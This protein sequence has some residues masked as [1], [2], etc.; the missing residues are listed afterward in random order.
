MRE[1]IKKSFKEIYDV[2]CER[3]YSHDFTIETIQL[4]MD[5][6]NE[7][8][9]KNNAE[10]VEKFR[11]QPPSNAPDF[12]DD[13]PFSFERIM[14]IFLRL[15]DSVRLITPASIQ[16]IFEVNSE[17]AWKDY[18]VRYRRYIY[19]TREN[20][21]D[22]E[23]LNYLAAVLYYDEKDFDMALKCIN[24][25]ISENSGSALYAH[26]KGLIL[27]HTGEFDSA[28]TYLYQALF[29]MELL[30]DQPPRLSGRP[31]IYPNY[32]IEYHTSADIIRMELN[33]IEQLELSFK[34]EVLALL[35]N[36]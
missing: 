26:L 15:D 24:Q 20:Y 33:K 25:A 18:Q 14:T 4:V 36:E 17:L 32:P 27:F 19:E 11:M 2:F 35:E 28:R 16:R 5:I 7:V 21:P 10:Y 30:Q 22:D 1:A 31:E 12:Y 8:F 34:H 29:L 9:I 3:S 6:G 23:Y 13:E